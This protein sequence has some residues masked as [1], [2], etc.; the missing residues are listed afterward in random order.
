MAL[1]KCPDC[2]KQ[3]SDLAP[4]C[5]NCGRPMILSNTITEPNLNKESSHKEIDSTISSRSVNL[6]STIMEVKKLKLNQD[7]FNFASQKY[8]Y[9][10]LVGLFYKN[11]TRTKNFITSKKASLKL[12]IKNS[13]KILRVSASL[14]HDN[15]EKI[16]KAYGIIREMSFQSRVNFYLEQLSSAGFIKYKYWNKL[17]EAGPASRTITPTSVRIHTDGRVTKGNKT[18]DLKIAKQNG[19]LWFGG[20]WGGGFNET[21]DPAQV[22]IAETNVKWF[23]QMRTLKINALWDT[24]IIH[25]I[26]RALSEGKSLI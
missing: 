18:Y 7:Y 17:V 9:S 24:D 4:S 3:I 2:N 5:I 12:N 23:T 26:I 8:L 6:S 15:I 14:I 1:I 16:S 10:D 13:D 19:I 21:R 11:E 22:V 25:G 20:H